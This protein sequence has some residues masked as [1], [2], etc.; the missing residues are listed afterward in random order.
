MF[1]PAPAGINL[2]LNLLHFR[3]TARKRLKRFMGRLKGDYFDNV[4]AVT[5]QD[6]ELMTSAIDRTG[7]SLFIEIGTGKGFST[8]GIFRHLL[9]RFPRCDFYTIDIFKEYLERV[10]DEFSSHPTFHACHGLSI[11]R[12]ETTDPAYKE[13]KSYHGPQNTLRSLFEN[14][15]KGRSVDI[16]FIDSRKGT[17]VPE[18]DVLA[19]HLSNNGYIFC[20]DV[21]N[22]GKG[23]ELVSHLDTLRDSFRY[24]VMD[25]GPAGM[26]R[27][28]RVAATD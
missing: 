27:I 22:G 23:V 19:K 8:R 14:E 25:T 6:L 20:H 5:A 12:E 21:L 24:E 28:R 13:L 26:I 9:D 10:N 16:A 17:A 4:G 18:F 1:L 11:L 3:R 7:P 15:L 2:M